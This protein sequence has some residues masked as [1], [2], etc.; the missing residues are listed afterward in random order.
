VPIEEEEEEGGGGGTGEDLIRSIAV[1]L[2][3]L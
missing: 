1:Q 3:L 2:T